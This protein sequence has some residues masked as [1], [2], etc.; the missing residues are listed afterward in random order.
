MAAAAGAAALPG[1]AAAAAAAVARARHTP[2]QQLL[3]LSVRG[4]AVGGFFAEQCW[5][6][7]PGTVSHD[8]VPRM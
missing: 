1:A 6:T 8:L 4:V 2:S 3:S 7:V 5:L